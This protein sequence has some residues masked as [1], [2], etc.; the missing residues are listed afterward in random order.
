MSAKKVVQTESAQ[1]EFGEV[2]SEGEA[3][4][5]RG[6]SWAGW[7]AEITGFDGAFALISATS[8]KAKNPYEGRV[9]IHNLRK[10]EGTYSYDPTPVVV[11]EAADD[12]EAEADEADA[13]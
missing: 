5:V 4:A 9:R 8:P 13:S 1:G 3:V 6:T 11:E 7:S 10:L 2:F 12:G